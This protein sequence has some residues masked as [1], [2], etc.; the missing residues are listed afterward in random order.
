MVE[1]FVCFAVDLA[2]LALDNARGNTDSRTIL[3][4]GFKN[5]S[6]RRDFGVVADLERTEYLCARPDHNAV[7]ERRVTLAGVLTGTAEGDTLVERTVVADLRRFTDD[8]ACAVVDEEALADGRTGVD[9]NAGDRACCLADGACGEEVPFFVQS[10]R[11]LVCQYCMQT[12]VEQQHF[13]V[14]G[15]CGVALLDNTDFVT[16]FID[17]GDDFVCCGDDVRMTAQIGACPAEG[18]ADVTEQR[19]TGIFIGLRLLCHKYVHNFRWAKVSFP[20]ELGLVLRSKI[21][22]VR[23]R[24][25]QNTV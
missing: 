8:D 2:V 16:D 25:P 20:V 24:K 6:T 22:V 10:V 1:V 19:G 23:Q 21:V 5:N 9:L 15:C 14:R 11:Y 17:C 4:D 12:G 7:A 18:V 3:G 13:K